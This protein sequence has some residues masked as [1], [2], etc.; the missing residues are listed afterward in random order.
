MCG[1]PP[2][3]PH[4]YVTCTLQRGQV[5]VRFAD[6]FRRPIS[7]NPLE[8]L[9]LKLAIESLTPPNEPTPKVVV[10]LLKKIEEGMSHQHRARFRALARSVV[11]TAP[12]AV[13]PVVARLRE[14]VRD[15]AEVE[16]EHSAPGKKAARR[17]VRPLGLLSRH[18]AWYLVAQDAGT[19]R[20]LSFRL[21]RISK[22]KATATRFEAPEDFTLENYARRAPFEAGETVATAVVRFRGSSAR[23]IREIAEAGTLK[24]S[25]EEMVWTAPL[26]S[27]ASFASFL[28]GIGA[29]FTVEK[30]ESLR[31]TVASMVERVIRA[32]SAK[33]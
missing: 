19:G 31:K 1:T 27:E 2:Y 7:L 33:R 10:D 23:W 26:L 3:Q 12:G 6:Q 20:I 11:A 14:A 21:D 18:G 9:S 8:A 29:E 17:T 5:T 28:L 22:V 15:Q 16:V 30:P 4:D 24:Q 25:G 32:H 13:G